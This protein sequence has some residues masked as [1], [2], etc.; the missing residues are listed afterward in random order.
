[1]TRLLLPL[2]FLAALP[3]AACGEGA[4]APEALDEGVPLLGEVE[5]GEYR[6]GDFWNF[7]DDGQASLILGRQGS[8]MVRLQMRIPNDLPATSCYELDIT[9][10]IEGE[11]PGRTILVRGAA[12]RPGQN[13]PGF[14]LVLGPAAD[15]FADLQ[16]DLDVVLR[17][18]SYAVAGAVEDIYLRTS[19]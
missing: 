17:T 11:P 18:P 12:L 5:L 19:P 2:T 7:A 10:N 8:W 16:M 14:E 1:M 9:P 13:P 15:S 6:N 4:C 3:L